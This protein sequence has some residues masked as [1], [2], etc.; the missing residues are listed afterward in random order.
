M[1][2]DPSLDAAAALCHLHDGSPEPLAIF[3]EFWDAAYGAMTS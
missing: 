3:V 2:A 1:T